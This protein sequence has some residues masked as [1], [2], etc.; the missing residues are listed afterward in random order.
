M[1]R[2]PFNMPNNTCNFIAQH[3][4][5]EDNENHKEKKIVFFSAFNN[6]K[7]LHSE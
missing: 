1:M 6:N 7:L 4:S 3:S 2:D 5:E